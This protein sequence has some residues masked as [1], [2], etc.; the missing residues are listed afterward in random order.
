MHP[1][2]GAL[3]RK[4]VTHSRGRDSQPVLW[5]QPH[6]HPLLHS[7]WWGPLQHQPLGPKSLQREQWL[8]PAQTLR[9]HPCRARFG[10]AAWELKGQGTRELGVPDKPSACKVYKKIAANV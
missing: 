9:L 5:I 4:V 2:H 7:R 6:S 10:G 3:V 1:E 8:P